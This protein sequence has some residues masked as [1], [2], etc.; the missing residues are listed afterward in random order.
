M[1][2]TRTLAL[3]LFTATLLAATAAFGLDLK[4]AKDQGLVKEQASGYLAAASGSP[5]AEVAALIADVNEKR[6]KHYQGIAD[7]NGIPVEAVAAQAGAKL[8]Q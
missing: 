6:K 1:R 7:K 3:S 4:T 2:K 5:S 8:T